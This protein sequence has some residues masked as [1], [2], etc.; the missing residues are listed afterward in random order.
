M[1]ANRH[2]KI[3]D[4]HVHL[5]SDHGDRPKPSITEV[6]GGKDAEQLFKIVKT[7]IDEKQPIDTT[8]IQASS[9]ADQDPEA[10]F[11]HTVVPIIDTHTSKVNR[12]FIYSER[13]Q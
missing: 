13:V 1:P 9:F 2:V 12:L 6:F 5:E 4:G 3:V 11:I 10:R 7:A 8:P